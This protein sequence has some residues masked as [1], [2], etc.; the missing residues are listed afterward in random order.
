MNYRFRLI[1]LISLILWA[2]IAFAQAQ[3]YKPFVQASSSD[4]TLAETTAEVLEKL[5]AADFVVAGQ[6]SPF[7]ETNIIVVTSDQL[8]AIASESDRGAYAAS[9][10]ISVSQVGDA[11]EVGFVNPLYIQHAYRLEGDS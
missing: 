4:S 11:I 10:R 2:G 8:M 7:A 6:Y 5:A 3:A 1:V 9:Q